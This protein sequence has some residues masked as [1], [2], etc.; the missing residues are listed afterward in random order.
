MA[1]MTAAVWLWLHN[2]IIVAAP[3]A[4]LAVGCG[5]AGI[6]NAVIYP[7]ERARRQAM[8]PPEPGAAD[9]PAAPP[10]PDSR[11]ITVPH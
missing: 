6:D 5:W 3:V 2:V 8:A 10:P 7:K 11:E 1:L 4:F 9:L